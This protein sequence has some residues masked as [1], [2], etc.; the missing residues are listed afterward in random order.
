MKKD[1]SEQYLKYLGALALTVATPATAAQPEAAP[2]PSSES[3]VQASQNLKTLTASMQAA[4]H[5]YSIPSVPPSWPESTYVRRVIY[6]PPIKTTV[7]ERQAPVN[8]SL[9]QLMDEVSKKSV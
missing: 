8:T 3:E 1:S 5:G 7:A 2:M 6:I 4:E 9:S